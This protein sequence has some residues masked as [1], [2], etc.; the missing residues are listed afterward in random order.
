MSGRLAW[1]LMLVSIAGGCGATPASGV[2]G[3]EAAGPEAAGP[4]TAAPE[5]STSAA[6]G[7]DVEEPAAAAPGF[8]PPD[9]EWS[10]G[11]LSVRIV[12]DVAGPEQAALLR[13]AEALDPP[14]EDVLALIASRPRFVV[15]DAPPDGPLWWV[16]AFDGVRIAYAVTDDALAY[17]AATARA[18]ADGDFSATAGIEMTMGGLQYEASVGHEERFERDG[19]SFENVDVVRMTLRWFQYCGGECAMGF[20]KERVVVFD[21]SGV[22]LA[23]FGDG[24]VDVLVS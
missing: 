1:T 4:A 15:R 21:A 16:S 13:A 22:M 24:M 20:E 5:T 7:A 2:A 12:R 17:Y 3:P 10:E 23:V 9:V 8:D 19:R 18:F 11:D 6:G 14:R